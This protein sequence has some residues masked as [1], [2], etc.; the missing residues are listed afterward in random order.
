MVMS[1]VNTTFFVA[2]VWEWYILTWCTGTD[3]KSDSSD[4]PKGG[5]PP[6]QLS[7]WR[8]TEKL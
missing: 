5:N 2:P 8:N 1:F 6:Y 7:S 4:K 3:F